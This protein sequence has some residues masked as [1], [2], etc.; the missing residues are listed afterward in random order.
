MWFEADGGRLAQFGMRRVC[1]FALLALGC[2][3]ASVSSETGSTTED[4][5][6]VGSLGCPCTDGGVCD[7]GLTC[8]SMICVDA[9]SGSEDVSESATGVDG[10]G[11]TTTVGDGDGDGD[12]TTGGDGDGDS[13]TAGD[14]D[15]DGDTTGA[16]DGD[17]D[18]TT[19]G[20]GDGDGDTTTTGDGDGDGDTTTGGD[21]DGDTTT[22]GDGD[23][24]GD[25]T[26]GGDGDG[27][28]DT[29]TG[30]DGD[31][32]GDTTTG[33]D[34]DGDGCTSW[35]RQIGTSGTDSARGAAVAANGDVLVGGS[36]SGPLEGETEVGSGDAF[37]MRMSP[38]GSVIWTTL[39]GSISSDFTEDLAVAANGDLILA[40]STL[41][42]FEGGS[43]QG[44]DDMW[45]ARVDGAG[46]LDWATQVG[47][48]A[49]DEGKGV[50]VDAAG[51]IYVVG[52]SSSDFGGETGLGH[53]DA[54]LSKFNSSGEL[55]WTR[56]IGTNVEDYGSG[57]AVDALGGII[58]VGWTYG[59][60]AGQTLA[61][62]TDSFIARY[63]AAG[64]QQWVR[65]IG[66]TQND[67]ATAVT[68][69][70][71]GGIYLTGF[72]IGSYQ[73]AQPMSST[74]ADAVLVKYDT[75]GNLIWIR[76]WGTSDSEVSLAVCSVSGGGVFAGGYVPTDLYSQAHQGGQDGFL[77][78]YSS[79]GQRY[80]DHQY[81]TSETEE[82]RD[83]SPGPFPGS[84]IAVGFTGGEYP[85][86]TAQGG[87]SDATVTLECETGL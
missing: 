17:G 40:G 16:G 29:T 43:H 36:A 14:G 42:A 66:S 46:A 7:P 2:A 55:Q 56:L 77:T 6:P 80:S 49:K 72:S 24:D 19:A 60:F 5:C 28:G 74:G 44:D 54:F 4:S 85:G 13:T 10:D 8:L 45:V 52:R 34:G 38:A 65:Q 27:D 11:D 62:G 78:R 9:G 75:D 82:F 22:G 23:G 48:S 25:T 41:G 87:S 39:F 76:Q 68:V 18:S 37:A 31:G 83:C 86:E 1:L 21:G 32:D 67:Q 63:D 57:V 73:G 81:G 35:T 3:P 15:G 61:G 64:V 26:T 20:D 71:D 53:Y 84:F 12:T 79:N 69:G 33:G 70:E 58:V 30:G 59:T 50:A 51:D 47:T